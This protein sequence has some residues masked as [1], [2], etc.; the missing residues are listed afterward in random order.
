MNKV[1]NKNTYIN[2]NSFFLGTF[3]LI[4]ATNAFVVF[5]SLGKYFFLV[6]GLSLIIR[7]I[8]GLNFFFKKNIFTVFRALVFFMILLFI[9]YELG[10]QH[11]LEPMKV[12]FGIV[13]LI[14]FLWGAF[15]KKTPDNFELNLDFRI[16]LLCSLF[17]IFSSYK[18]YYFQLYEGSD[19][20]RN[21][22]EDLNAVGVAYTHGQLFLI[23]AFLL[24]K[25][26]NVK[27]KIVVVIA[28]FS[29]LA[30]M[31][32]TES[33]GALLYLVVTLLM[34]YGSFFKKI[35]NPK[36]VIFVMIILLGSFFI[37]RNNP[38]IKAK[39]ERINIRF[40]SM[41]N[42]LDQSNSY[43]GSLE[44]REQMQKVFFERYNEMYFGYSE[45]GFYPHNQFIEIFMRWG[46]LGLPLIVISLY[47]I[48]KSILFVFT[49]KRTNE[50]AF[51]VISIFFFSYLQ[52]M[53]S[54]SLE[55]NRFMWLGFGYILISKKKI[56]TNSL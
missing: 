6:V 29:V 4:S 44:E 28:L 17:I 27:V 32:F 37:F 23:F 26:N 47:C 52:S 22:G 53:S 10:H 24:K 18:F 20:G 43:D 46:L 41:I 15:F 30:T 2:S 55:M 42:Y 50:L 38:V 56:S 39:T 1:T 45:Y 11:L 21:V 7:S 14:L 33:R 3:M 35:L 25:L 36:R 5:G 49:T 12:F 8:N 34:F 51:F 31:M 13:C 54:L 9:S 19:S 48:A 16:I 40:T